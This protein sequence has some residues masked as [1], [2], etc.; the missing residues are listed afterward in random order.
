MLLFAI[1]IRQ[2]EAVGAGAGAAKAKPAAAE[3][4]R[5]SIIRHRERNARVISTC[6]RRAQFANGHRFGEVTLRP[7]R[8]L[9]SLLIASQYHQEASESRRSDAATLFV[10][11]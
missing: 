7:L 3:S 8:V 1:S 4:C 5:R 9:K 2:P 10:T 11:R 6:R